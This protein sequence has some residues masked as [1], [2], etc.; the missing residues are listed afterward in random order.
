MKRVVLQLSGGLGN[1]LFQYHAGYLYAK[2]HDADLRI[3]I[4]RTLND[5]AIS[6]RRHLGMEQKGILAF[7]LPD[8]RVVGKHCLSQITRSNKYLQILDIAGV[9]KLNDYSPNG[10]IGQTL[11]HLDFQKS[12]PA[13]GSTRLK[14][15]FQSLDL[16]TEAIRRGS[17]SDPQLVNM[18]LRLEESLAH[19]SI[20]NSLAIHIRLT[21]YLTAATSTLIGSDYYT[22]AFKATY[23]EDYFESVFIFSDDIALCRKLLPEF[24]ASKVTNWVSEKDFSDAESFFLMTNFSSLIISNSTFSYFAAYYSKDQA[25]ITAPN[26]WFK[27]ENQSV[28]LKYPEGWKLLSV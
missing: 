5:K 28:S 6:N 18:S 9:T 8:G 11:S 1:Q 25:S 16:V 7:N 14:G 21:D 2:I 23:K 15:Y 13:I 27:D 17:I 20:G 26:P 4:S 22:R 3:D 24:I 10:E 19:I 12:L